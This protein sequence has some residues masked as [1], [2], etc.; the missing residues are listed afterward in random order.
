M[1]YLIHKESDSRTKEWGLVGQ[2]TSC[3]KAYQVHVQSPMQKGSWQV[4][5]ALQS[6]QLVSMRKASQLRGAYKNTTPSR[7]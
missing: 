3:L 6:N 5:Q 2:R 1:R 4:E 7:T